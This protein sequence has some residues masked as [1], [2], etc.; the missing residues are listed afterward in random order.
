M[1]VP[2]LE[3]FPDVETAWIYRGICL[4]SLSLY[5]E[6][7][8]S[9][10][11]ALEFAHDILRPNAWLGKGELYV[12]KGDSKAALSCFHRATEIDPRDGL[13]WSLIGET[14][15]KSGNLNRAEDVLCSS[16]ANDCRRAE[17]IYSVLAQVLTAQGIYPE[18]KDYYKTALELNPDFAPAFDGYSD[19][20]A[21]SQ[22]TESNEVQSDIVNYIDDIDCS[23]LSFLARYIPERN[24]RNHKFWIYYGQA[25]GRLW[26]YDE[27]RAA[28]QR[29]RGGSNRGML[30]YYAWSFEG[31]MEKDRGNYSAA[32]HCFENAIAVYPQSANCYVFLSSVFFRAGDLDRAEGVLRDALK[33]DGDKD[34]ALFNLGGILLAQERY[35][36]AV[37]CYREAIKID[38]DYT[39][40]KIRLLD[41]EHTLLWRQNNL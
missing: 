8:K 13:I 28:F 33:L 24:E 2:Y 39:I 32:Q 30:V 9:F 29:A 14:L 1:I 20:V 6:A 34:E 22:L 35:P 23:P 37:Q 26:R 40:A 38:P 10:E 41:V 3:D 4:T 17:H 12:R 36:E 5:D 18:A 31:Q 7:Q 25:L 27:A 11:R 16:L 15:L 19:L 21:F